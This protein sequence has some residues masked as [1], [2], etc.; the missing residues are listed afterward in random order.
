MLLV[1][2]RQ[3]LRAAYTHRIRYSRKVAVGQVG[4]RNEEEVLPAKAEEV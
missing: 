4:W 1:R 2:N 3:Q